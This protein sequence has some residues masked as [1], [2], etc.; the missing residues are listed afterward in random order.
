MLP[1]NSS[2]AHRDEPHRRVN[3]PCDSEGELLTGVGPACGLGSWSVSLSFS[4]PEYFCLRFDCETAHRS[5]T[6]PGVGT[7]RVVPVIDTCIGLP[8]WEV[9]WQ[10]ELDAERPV[11]LG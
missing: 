6:A 9:T 11:E 7:S 8:D 2:A 4:D 5:G 1:D 10:R 3:R